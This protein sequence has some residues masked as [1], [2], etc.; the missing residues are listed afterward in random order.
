[1]QTTVSY[2]IKF[3]NEEE[4]L[5]K[6]I[7][8]ILM[9]K[10]NYVHE[11]IFVN[12]N[13]TDSSIDYVKSLQANPPK[14]TIIKLINLE[15]N[16][17]TFAST[18]NIGIEQATGQYISI[19]TAHAYWQ[20]ENDLSTMLQNFEIDDKVAVVTPRIFVD[21]RSSTLAKLF[22]KSANEPYKI[23]RNIKY[24]SLPVDEHRIG[25]FPYMATFNLIKASVF[26]D[27]ANFF[28]ELPRS[29]DL[30]WS[31]RIM[32]KGFS[33]VYEP[34]VLVK[35]EDNDPIDE[36]KSIIKKITNRWLTAVTA[37]III[38]TGK[39]PSKWQLAKSSLISLIPFLLKA[40]IIEKS[41]HQK[42]V[43]LTYVFI[44]GAYI[45]QQVIFNYNN[46]ASWE[47]R[48]RESIIE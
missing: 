29:E 44:A 47:Q 35:H 13:T 15:P 46:Y 3:K 42:L 23:I 20:T 27:K 8:S 26:A 30:D 2:I 9:Q 4:F 22:K 40:A 10:G 39:A 14:N 25:N 45:K 41:L 17:F 19:V 5:P 24:F 31:Q 1:M 32:K 7:D 16:S 33:F 28:R 48:Y 34:E 11:L 38:K 37:I 18:N 21:E 12:D 6:C 43:Y 36:G